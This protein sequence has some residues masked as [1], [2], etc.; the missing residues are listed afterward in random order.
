MPKGMEKAEV[1][2]AFFMSVYWYD[3]SGIISPQEQQENLPS[4]E[5]D[6][7]MEHLNKLDRQIHGTCWDVLT[8]V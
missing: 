8:N 2:N 6:Q 4:A 3:L 5:K 1:L 7:V